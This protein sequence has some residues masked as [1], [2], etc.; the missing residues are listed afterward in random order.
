[1]KS[2]IYGNYA[3]YKLNQLF[4]TSLNNKIQRQK[5]EIIKSIFS[6]K[7]SNY[8]NKQ[9]LIF[10]YPKKEESDKMKRV[11]F[12]LNEKIHFKNYIK[13]NIAKGKN[14]TRSSFYLRYVNEED[15]AKI[16]NDYL[17]LATEFNNNSYKYWHYFATFNYK[18]YRYIYN[19][20]KGKNDN[21]QTKIKTVIEY[22]S[23]SINGLKHSLLI[24]NKSKVRALEDSLRF[25]DIFFE[26]GNK[27][28]NLLSQIESIINEADLEIFIGIIPQLTCRFDIKDENV[29][30]ILIKLLSNILKTYPEVILFPLISIKNSKTKKSKAIVERIMQRTIENNIGLKEL[31]KEYE[32][33]VKELNK[34]SLL[35]HEEW[36]ETIETSAKLYLNQFYNNMVSQITKLHN[37]INKAPENL[38]EINF[39]Q[40]YGNDLKKAEK[41]INKCL[42]KKK[43]IYLKEAWAIYQKVYKSI[44]E[45]YSNFQSISLQYISSK[46]FNFK[47]SNI[48]IPSFSHSFLYKSNENNNNHLL[49][50]RTKD[51]NQTNIKPITIKQIDKYLYILDSKQHPRKISMIGTNNKEYIYLLKGHDD[52]RQDE[53]VIQIFNL[54]NLIMSKEKKTSNLQSLIS[55]YSVIPL[56]NKSGLIGWVPNC[57]SLEELIKEYRKINNKIQNIEKKYLLDFNPGYET[58]SLLPKVDAFL[59]AIHKSK[60]IDLRQI[61]WHKSKDCESW[62]IRTTNYSRSLAVMSIVG[63]ILGLG[64]RHLNNILMNRETGKIVHIDLSD[65]FEI[66]MKRDKFPEK[67]PFRL[68]RML[69]RA[70]GITEVEGN[71]RITCEKTLF[72]LKYNRDSL[73][74]ILSALV[75][76]PLISFRLLI[77]LIMKKRRDEFKIEAPIE[78]KDIITFEENASSN[79]KKIEKKNNKR[80]SNYNKNITE[81]KNKEEDTEGKDERQIMERE[82]RQILGLFEETEDIDTDE[83]YKIAQLI[84]V[85]INNKL[86][87]IHHN[88]GVQLNEKEQVEFLIREARSYENLVMS[89]LGWTPY[90]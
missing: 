1:M 22:A 39:H 88:N 54:V 8:L 37:K 86:I 76:N 28:K 67:V 21:N 71:F 73:I 38:Y 62:F 65:C 55:I 25:I 11:K 33:F 90:W 44:K 50:K 58:S 32:E 31:Y 19:Q 35:Y 46:L 83:L 51:L 14:Y 4:K 34:C 85:R 40:L 57:D 52:L 36:I 6:K 53:R 16:V 74:A 87:G 24:S 69:V 72:M 59:Y 17:R 26:L 80:L 47:D 27:D 89:Y 43:L 12:N 45:N 20:M 64:D 66:A 3:I 48:I 82:Q 56:S 7:I 29:L 5:R 60:D 13:E 41:I 63:Y 68:T 9:N 79:N 78:D 18:Y 61:I 23:N 42:D 10:T 15:D 2:K 81:N 70:L 30:E 49:N 77:P 75:H 84:I